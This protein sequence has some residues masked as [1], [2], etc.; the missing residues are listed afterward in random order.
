MYQKT[1]SRVQ[2]STSNST[3]KDPLTGA[4]TRQKLGSGFSQGVQIG[5]EIAKNQVK[6][7]GVKAAAAGFG[8]GLA[9]GM[10]GNKKKK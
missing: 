8:V 3:V 9:S 4:M 7:Q 10:F 6:K 2:Q 1:R 5:A